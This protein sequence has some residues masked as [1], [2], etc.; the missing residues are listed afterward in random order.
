MRAL[1]TAPPL[2]PPPFVH[3][4]PNRRSHGRTPVHKGGPNC[5]RFR[6]VDLLL[7]LRARQQASD[8]AVL[9]GVLKRVEDPDR[10]PVE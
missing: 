1:H 5:Q 2:P 3:P 4:G 9:S 10:V 7:L 6:W 8:V